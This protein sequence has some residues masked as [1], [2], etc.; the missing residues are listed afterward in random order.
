[1]QANEECAACDRYPECLSG[2]PT[3]AL[4]M[5]GDMHKKN[6]LDCCCHREGYREKM[7]AVLARNAASRSL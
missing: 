2:C 1:L 6:P 4:A 5:M 3:A 7:D